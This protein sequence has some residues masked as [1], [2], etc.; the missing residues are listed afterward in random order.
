MKILKSAI[1]LFFF[2]SCQFVFSQTSKL[3][4]L[5]SIKIE[6]GNYI[7]SGVV[8]DENLKREIIEKI[9]NQ[10][11]DATDFTRLKVE[12]NAKS[13]EI[14][15]R[16]EFDAT[17]SE[18][19]SWKSGVF[20]FS[21]KIDK[22]GE[23]FP[24]L[25][26]DILNAKF[27]LTDNKLVSLADYKNKVVVLFFLESWCG[28][29][30][31]L[32]DELNEFYSKVSSPNLEI[33]GLSM[34][35]SLEEKKDFRNFVRRRKF[36]YKMGWTDNQLFQYFYKISNLNGIPQGFVICDGKL[37]GVFLGGSQRVNKHLKETVIKTLEDKNL[38][39]KQ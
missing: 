30:I 18:L 32:A 12:P 25:A 13:F 4:S 39:S 7:V 3:D 9:N 36:N 31:V 2:L 27:F 26:E 14:D 6:K 11:G 1:F 10:L 19:K 5:I 15:W 17:L 21:G 20:T 22:K 8:A 34:E 23:D 16:K 38:P 28:P 35:T 33:M 24:Q 37:Y 29:C